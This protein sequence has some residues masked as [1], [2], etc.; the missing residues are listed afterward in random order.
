MFS[1]GKRSL[2]TATVIEE[3]RLSDISLLLCLTPPLSL[4]SPSL[5]L[6]IFGRRGHFFFF[7]LLRN[8]LVSEQDGPAE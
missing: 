8:G 3:E 7:L 5:L 1:A 2:L 6:L 4:G